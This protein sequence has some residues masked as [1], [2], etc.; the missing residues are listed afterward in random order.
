MAAAPP[1]L[2]HGTDPP[3]PAH[4]ARFFRTR[5]LR[6]NR[7]IARK[8]RDSVITWLRGPHAVHVAMQFTVCGP[9]HHVRE[10]EARDLQLMPRGWRVAVAMS[11]SALLERFIK[12]PPNEAGLTLTPR[13][14][15]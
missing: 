4:P 3:D 13:D 11:P 9:P 7:A 8:K 5:I 12:H 6:N 2:H 10:T 14:E 1:S 15:G